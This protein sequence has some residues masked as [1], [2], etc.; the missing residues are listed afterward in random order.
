MYV[1]KSQ[2]TLFGKE[3]GLYIEE[4]RH[5]HALTAPGYGYSTRERHNGGEEA[6]FCYHRLAPWTWWVSTQHCTIVLCILSIC[7]MS[8]IF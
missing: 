1:Y 2:C 5:W 3:D 8:L 7:A 6:I 4:V